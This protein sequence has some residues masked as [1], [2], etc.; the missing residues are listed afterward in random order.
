MP[1]FT[2]SVI[3]MFMQ[4]IYYLSRTIVLVDLISD[5]MDAASTPEIRFSASQHL[6]IHRTKNI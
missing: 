1:N 2:E 5:I 4:N 6:L 3:T